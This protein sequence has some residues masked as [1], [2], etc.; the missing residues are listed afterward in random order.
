LKA[1][2]KSKYLTARSTTLK[3]IMVAS[4][5]SG[6]LIF[7]L[8]AVNSHGA[9]V[10]DLTSGSTTLEILKSDYSDLQVINGTFNDGPSCMGTYIPSRT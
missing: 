5:F 10:V 4:K 8:T 1:N 6:W 7:A 9:R 2:Q 3:K